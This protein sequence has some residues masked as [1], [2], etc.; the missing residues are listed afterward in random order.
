MQGLLVLCTIHRRLCNNKCYAGPLVDPLKPLE[1]F[2]LPEKPL[3][4]F[5]LINKPLIFAR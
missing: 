3:I 5:I 1:T 2:N 4:T